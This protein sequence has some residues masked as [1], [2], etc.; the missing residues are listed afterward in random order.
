M[1]GVVIAGMVAILVAYAWGFKLGK[2]EGR[3]CAKHRRRRH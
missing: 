2:D 1:I 3:Y